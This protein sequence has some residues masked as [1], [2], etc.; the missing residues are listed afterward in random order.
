METGDKKKDSHCEE[1]GESLMLYDDLEDTKIT[2]GSFPATKTKIASNEAP[3]KVDRGA[4]ISVDV[5]D[6]DGNGSN[7][8]KSLTEQLVSLQSQVDTLQRENQ[9]L[10]RNIGTLFRTARSEIKRK[11]D[12]IAR[13]THELDRIPDQ[14]QHRHVR[15]G[16]KH[17]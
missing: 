15:E 5:S 12:E 2:R 9:T 7:R 16:G 4:T 1:N 14:Q 11:D 13:L 8:P 6:N 10:R 17:H 3:T